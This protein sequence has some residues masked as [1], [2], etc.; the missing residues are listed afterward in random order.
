MDPGRAEATGQSREAVTALGAQGSPLPTQDAVPCAAWSYAAVANSGNITLNSATLVDSYQSSL[1]AYGG[2]NTGS[3]AIVQA[4]TTI[5]ANGGTVRGSLRANSASGFAVVPVVAGAR[6]L[7]LGSA[8]PGS[9]NINN[10]TQSITLPP[11]DY[12]AANINVNFPGSIVISPAGRV[13]IWVTGTLNLGGNENLNGIPRNLAF[14]VTSSG[15]VNVNTSGALY[16]MIYAPTSVVNVNS[17]IFG[18][19]IARSMAV[20][21]SGGAIH[22]DQG[23]SCTQVSTAGPQSGL[24]PLPAPPPQPGCY[25]GTVNGWLAMPCEDPKDILPGFKSFEVSQDGLSTYGSTP[26]PTLLFGQV[27]ATVT[28][29]DHEKGDGG[30]DGDPGDIPQWSIQ[31][32]SNSFNC[33]GSA[34]QTCLV[35]FVAAHNGA[36]GHT[37]VCIEPWRISG[38]SA[39]IDNFCVGANGQVVDVGSG[40]QFSANGRQ[41]GLKAGD[42]ANIAGYSYMTNNTPMMAM[43]AQFSWVSPD[44]V[45]PTSATTLPNRIPG[46]YAVVT[47]DTYGLAQG[48]NRVTGGI[49]GM[50]NQAKAIFT[51]AEVYTRVA[52][53]NCAGDVSASGPTCPSN[54]ELSSSDVRFTNIGGQYATLETSNLTATQSTPEVVFPNKN[55]AVTSFVATTNVPSGSSTAACLPSAPSHLFI[56]DNEGDNGGVPSNTGGVPFWQSPDIFVLPLSAPKPTAFDTPADIEVTANVT[57]NVYLRVHNEFGCS[58]VSGPFSVF[59]DGADPNIGFA[60]WQKVTDGADQGQYTMAGAGTIIPAYGSGIIGPFQWTPMGTGH[61]CLLAAIA[62]SNETAPPASAAAPVLPPAYDSNQIA[63]RNLQ[64]G[65]SCA[66]NISAP[67]SGSA[68]LLLGISVSPEMPA[69]GASG[70]PSVSLVFQDPGGIWSAQWQGVPGLSSV[71]N[72]GSKTTIV[73]NS[74]HVALPSVALFQSPSVT[75]NVTSPGAPPTVNLSAL[76]T[77]P[78]TGTILLQNG[79]SCTGTQVISNGG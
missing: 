43:V 25:V 61:K 56:R 70:G 5:T 34:N 64:I 26:A 28:N 71:T 10:A 9:L 69:P 45:V 24:D 29:I 20:V 35:Q 31:N 4:A 74:S 39:T 52:A 79:G 54:L 13:R 49:M 58:A 75:L 60:N 18:S 36:S 15:T 6:N 32:N 68:N 23:S 77:D 66:Y 73:L 19:V 41:G 59:I 22:F 17:K 50:G 27:Q 63:Q 53:S 14:L 76:L 78:E 11:G 37:A 62:A 44:D 42:F 30:T 46:L 57:Y 21:N 67:S 51:N 16:G 1:G 3:N 47:P 8:T 38:T 2:A 55:L 7:P 72:D 40:L 33:S 48:W 12:V 65:S